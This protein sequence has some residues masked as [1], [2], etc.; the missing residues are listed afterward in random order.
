MR[1]AE[2]EF[3][4]FSSSVCCIWQGTVK[5]ADDGESYNGD[6]TQAAM[7]SSSQAV[8]FSFQWARFKCV[9]RFIISTGACPIIVCTLLLSTFGVGVG[10]AHRS[11][12]SMLYIHM[13]SM[14]YIRRGHSAVA[15]LSLARLAV[16]WP[17]SATICSMRLI[18]WPHPSTV[19][20][21]TNL[22]RGRRAVL[23]CLC[24][25]RVFVH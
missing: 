2:I 22:V 7:E 18:N 25:L 14:S 15:E 9:Y 13:S 11:T 21:A 10:A 24:C 4:F 17:W 23:F 6:R 3:V 5:I 8:R 12:K 16:A 19:V 1:T 20:H